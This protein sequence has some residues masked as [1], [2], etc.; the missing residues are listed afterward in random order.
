MV[1][2]E[3][4]GR[5]MTFTRP[6]DP[7]DPSNDQKFLAQESFGNSPL[8]ED[9]PIDPSLIANPGEAVG[10]SKE[11][12]DD[13]LAQVAAACGEQVQDVELEHIGSGWYRARGAAPSILPDWVAL[14]FDEYRG[15]D[16]T[17]LWR[18]KELGDD[19]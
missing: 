2:G 4:G 10:Y 14:N 8:R 9:E 12:V 13:L 1:G 6:S 11:E 18:S 16:G 17:R 7:T 19:A 3:G 5:V 15:A